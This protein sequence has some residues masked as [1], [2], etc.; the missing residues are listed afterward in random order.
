MRP[1]TTPQP[2][3]N[4][5]IGAPS[6][7][8][9]R[10]YSPDAPPELVEAVAL[11]ALA[12]SMEAEL[13]TCQLTGDAG[14]NAVRRLS[15]VGRGYVHFALAEPGRFATAFAPR[16]VPVADAPFRPSSH[17]ASQWATR[18]RPPTNCSSRRWPGCSTPA[19]SMRQIQ[20][21]RYRDAR[22]RRY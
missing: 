3:H 10:A 8:A 13:S 4:R 2:R 22:V 9:P 15:A 20:R 14:A 19:F 6:R 21:I 18:A 16:T 5:L 17:A 12:R 11:D 1:R 7:Q